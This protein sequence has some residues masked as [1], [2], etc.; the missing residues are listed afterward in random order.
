MS[1]KLGEPKFRGATPSAV[2]EKTKVLK[3]L[4]HPIVVGKFEVRTMT[5]LKVLEHVA[6]L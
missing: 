6:D 1:C 2:R 5:S 3:Q 4:C